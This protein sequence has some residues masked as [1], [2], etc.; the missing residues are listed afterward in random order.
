V[1]IPEDLMLK[2]GINAKILTERRISA[3]LNDPDIEKRLVAAG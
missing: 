3:I 2:H 1:Y